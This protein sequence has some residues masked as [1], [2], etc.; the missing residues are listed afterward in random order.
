M[1]V[2]LALN[3]RKHDRRLLG[4]ENTSSSGP[5][6]DASPLVQQTSH[7]KQ[8]LD[9]IHRHSIFSETH[10]DKLQG[11]NNNVPEIFLLRCSNP[12]GKYTSHLSISQHDC[13]TPDPNAQFNP[14]RSARLFTHPITIG[15][16]QDWRIL[17]MLAD[18]S[19]TN[20]RYDLWH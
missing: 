12:T 17:S 14:V 10:P 15:K 2:G 20:P 4:T 18:H 8:T 7:Q 19:G 1:V 16:D 6:L 3:I 13:D 11:Q 9:A 5:F